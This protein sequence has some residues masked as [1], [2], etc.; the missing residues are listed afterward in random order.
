[1]IRIIRPLVIVFTSA[2][3]FFSCQKHI[4][5][6]PNPPPENPI[7]PVVPPPVV[8]PTENDVIVTAS[9]Q[10][11]VT[12]PNGNP[13][14]NATV[15][16]AGASVQTDSNG[17][18][19]FHNIQMSKY[20][21][22]VKVSKSGF[23]TGS[24]TIVTSTTGVNY[25]KIQLTQRNNP[26]TFDAS[27]GGSVTNSSNINVSFPASA[28][29]TSSS[30][31]GYSGAVNLYS[32][33]YDPTD[34]TQRI[35]LPGD[36]R[37]TDTTNHTVG[38]NSLGIVSIELEG[39][40]GEKL[41]MATGKSAT[42]SLP[43]PSGLLSIAPATVSLWY[44]NDTTG[45]WIQQGV[46]T[47]SGNNYVGTVSHF[48]YWSFNLP[49]TIVYF[50]TS[51]KDQ[52]NNPLAYTRLDISNNTTNDTRT[53]YSDSL[54]NVNGWIEKNASLSFI[55]YD[56]CGT[57]LLIKSEGPFTSDQTLDPIIVPLTNHMITVHGT[58]V[59]C[60]NSPMLNGLANIM[61][62]GLAY[63]TPVSNGSYSVSIMRCSTTPVNVFV[64][65]TDNI[66][67]MSDSTNVQV[68]GADVD[69]GQ[70]SVCNINAD[71]YFV[72]NIDGNTYTIS[73][74]PAIFNYATGLQ[75]NNKAYTE[76]SAT[77]GS[78]GTAGYQYTLFH[79][80][81]TTTGTTFMFWQYLTIGNTRYTDG[82][83]TITCNVTRYDSPGG[84]VQGS[85]SGPMLI[86]STGAPHAM[87]G[88]FKVK[89]P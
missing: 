34:A 47:K 75:P 65:V 41:Q 4:D 66:S 78:P 31:T 2:L 3:I 57:S 69:A 7:K 10:G 42:I 1:M 13:V 5:A 68:N 40:A 22:F 43:I 58:V 6:S 46:A 26:G 29:V 62:D 73:D 19:R 11:L 86:D 36:L 71:Q 25:V 35:S 74:P 63:S 76:L 37:G 83:G 64:K 39:S 28:I 56:N 72:Y 15:S 88:I 24:R 32:A 53:G 51:L 48:T 55:V 60:S 89:N 77:N 20:F 16:G 59:D 70:L 84:Y 38:I 52:N 12:D 50:T 45:K 18:F 54:G 82:A 27:S 49:Y 61:L 23:F 85:F 17:M 44:F 8:P 87:T 80:Q 67:L 14:L 9:I 79:M 33:F 21:G 81:F 30:N